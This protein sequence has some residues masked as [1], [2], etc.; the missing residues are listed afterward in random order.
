MT[1]PVPVELPA[2]PCPNCGV[3]VV[4]RVCPGCA[5]EVRAVTDFVDDIGR[6]A[7]VR[8]AWQPDAPGACARCGGER[9]SVLI[10]LRRG[11]LC[12]KCHTA[13]ISVQTSTTTLMSMTVD[14]APDRR[15]GIIPIV[16]IVVVGFIVAA[17]VLIPWR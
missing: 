3:D 13:C 8:S 12:T 7:R 14:E 15:T 5:A 9:Q 6:P 11:T 1:V 2:L 16:L 4:N 17:I 10:D